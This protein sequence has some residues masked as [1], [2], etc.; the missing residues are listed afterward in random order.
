VQQEMLDGRRLLEVAMGQAFVPVLVPPWNRIRD[1]Y[2]P[3]AAKAG[4][5]AVS[6]HGRRAS[7]YVAPGV[8]AL[9]IHSGPLVWDA[10]GA[11]F[12]GAIAPLRSIVDH[13]RERRTGAC[14][15]DEPTGYCTHHRITDPAAWR[16]SERLLEATVNHPGVR[17]ISL[18]ELIPPAVPVTDTDATA[19]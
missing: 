16:F 18:Q 5:S 8:Q 13:L 19:S 4:F 14:D 2:L 11:R 1:E 9:N 7:R 10:G 3:L 15:A 12:A 17:W 6:T